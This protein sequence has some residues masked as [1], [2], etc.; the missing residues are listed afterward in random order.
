[1]SDIAEKILAAITEREKLAQAEGDDGFSDHESWHTRRCGYGQGEWLEPC[2]C[3]VPAAVLRDC[4]ADREIV[5]H[6]LGLITRYKELKSKDIM[7]SISIRSAAA[8]IADYSVVILP[9][10]ARRYE[11]QP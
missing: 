5:N 3:D 7:R 2:D 6:Y 10:L 9:A 11:I 8:L 1:M 4:A